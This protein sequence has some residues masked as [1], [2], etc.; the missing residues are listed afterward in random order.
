MHVNVQSTELVER[1]DLF[2]MNTDRAMHNATNLS[3]DRILG[4]QQL[5]MSGDGVIFISTT[6]QL[7]PRGNFLK[8]ILTLK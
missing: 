1:M 6:C 4:D 5:F 8:M 2:F 3:V 7:F